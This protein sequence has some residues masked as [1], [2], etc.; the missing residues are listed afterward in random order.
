MPVCVCTRVR[1]RKNTFTFLYCAWHCVC[2]GDWTKT[3]VPAYVP[4]FL[5]ECVC[6]NP[7]LFWLCGWSLNTKPRLTVW[8][9]CQLTCMC[10]SVWGSNL[11]LSVF[12]CVK[13]K[14][15]SAVSPCQVRLTSWVS[16]PIQFISEAATWKIPL[17][18]HLT[19]TAACRKQ[20]ENSH[21]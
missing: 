19:A 21:I 17:A 13:V 4:A 7:Q 18:S 14:R 9:M 15:Q 20:A 11:P 16:L 6:Y 2:E 10:I 1:D 8:E 5:G 3:N 12:G